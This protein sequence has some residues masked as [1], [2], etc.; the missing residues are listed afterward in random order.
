M[1]LIDLHAGQIQG[2][3]NI[4]VDNLYAAP[5]LLEHLKSRFPDGADQIVMVSPDA[6]G[7]ER[8]RAFAKRLGLHPGRHR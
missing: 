1:S 8:A 2:F 4:P 7:T 3:F 6:G 5:V